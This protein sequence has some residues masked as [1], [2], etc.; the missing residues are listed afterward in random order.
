MVKVD[1]DYGYMCGIGVMDECF[2]WWD[3]GV[4]FISVMV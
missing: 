4:I 3:E 1:V 2:K